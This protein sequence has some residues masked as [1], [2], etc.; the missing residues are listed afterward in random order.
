MIGI[1]MTGIRP[2]SHLNIRQDFQ[3]LATQA[4]VE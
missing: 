3:V 2:Y 1:F 4:I